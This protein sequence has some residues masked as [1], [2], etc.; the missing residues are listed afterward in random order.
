M[1]K[2]IE[3]FKTVLIIMLII[4]T[5]F[6]GA[7]SGVFNE[8]FG[9]ESGS[10]R[11]LFMHMS[12]SVNLPLATH[13]IIGRE[14]KETIPLFVSVTSAEGAHWATKYSADT[15]KE[16][17]EKTGNTISEA[18]GSASGETEVN[19]RQWRNALSSQGLFYDYL[20]P[21]S[22]SVISSWLGVDVSEEVGA[23][24]VRRLCVSSQNEGV[25]LYY[26][27]EDNGKFFRCNT[28]VR[29]ENLLLYAEEYLPNGSRFVF[30]MD[31]KYAGCDPYSIVVI[32]QAKPTVL[33]SENP[34]GSSVAVE[35]IVS[36]FGINPYSKYEEADGTQVFIEND[37][38]MRIGGDGVVRF[39]NSGET[40]GISDLEY[41]DMSEAISAVRNLI[42]ETM[43]KAS[44]EAAVM[45][46]SAE[47]NNET[48]VIRFGYFVDSI[49]VYLYNDGWA[50]E[51]VLEN[52]RLREAVLNFRK[53]SSIEETSA[54]LTCRYAAAA[55][56]DGEEPLLCYVDEGSHNTSASWIIDR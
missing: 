40:V 45:L 5:V 41:D 2:N 3:R 18:I 36:I 38:S 22:L 31:E 21:M 8:L 56:Q 19:E 34:I 15:L 35:D 16:V 10:V 33:K 14:V 9:L 24:V 25:Y 17:Y 47:S 55:A 48:F 43:E 26:K 53:Y 7:E 1:K 28:A 50:A 23:R 42:L 12:G 37:F 46:V 44:G 30:E 6:L 4:T 32:E 11:D 51:F 39:K 54:V 29:V 52:G 27:D 49:P 20:N 13:T